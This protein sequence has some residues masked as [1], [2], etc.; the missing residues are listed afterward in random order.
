MDKIRI[1]LK[2]DIGIL[3]LDI[4]AV[5]FAYILALIFR[6]GIDDAA[7]I[8]SQTYDFPSY[9]GIYLRFAP[10][11]T[12]VCILVFIVFRL[13]GSVWE[14]AGINDMYR[15]LGAWIVTT[16]F[17]IVGTSILVR[18]MM[19]GHSRMPLTYYIVGSALQLLFVTAIRFG[20]RYAAMAKRRRQKKSGKAIILGAGALGTLTMNVLQEGENYEVIAIVDTKKEHVGLL[21]NGVP[22]FGIETLDALLEKNQVS[23]VFLAEPD[24]NVV[25]RMKI[26]VSC[27]RHGVELKERRVTE[28]E[29]NVTE[30][31]FVIPTT[32]MESKWVEQYKQQYGEEP[33]FF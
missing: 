24:L 13:Y 29:E 18:V 7:P 21:L 9:F 5:N 32:K 1:V 8:F 27:K 20:R 33:S 16:V 25:D 19:S 31:Q 23:C 22:V 4:L 28:T 15:I 12:L 11:Y 3:L 17:H 14:F 26:A 30:D 2:K 6:A 10:I